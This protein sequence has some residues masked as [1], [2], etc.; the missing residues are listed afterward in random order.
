MQ[1]PV[2]RFFA[3]L[4]SSEISG[5]RYT[6]SDGVLIF[7]AKCDVLA[8]NTSIMEGVE[9]HLSGRLSNG[10]RSECPTHLAWMYH[11]LIEFCLDLTDDPV[12]SFPC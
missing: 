1:A 8:R 4:E 10:L 5:S 12:K 6:V 7:V 9:S 3:R 2:E 11:R